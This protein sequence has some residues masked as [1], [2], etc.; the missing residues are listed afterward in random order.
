[1]RTAA[2]ICLSLFLGSCAHKDSY[3]ARR[4]SY[5]KLLKERLTGAELGVEGRTVLSVKA[6]RFDEVALKAQSELVPGFELRPQDAS[7]R[8]AVVA[9]SVNGREAYGVDQLHFV[10]NG[11]RLSAREVSD[12]N[13]VETLYPFAFPFMK[14]FEI[15]TPLDAEVI[16]VRSPVGAVVLR[17]SS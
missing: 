5:L 14:I 15:Q 2:L 11:K 17:L 4:S 1:M 8:V 9:V 10:V 16:E 6:V 7:S 3:S 12:L 13:V